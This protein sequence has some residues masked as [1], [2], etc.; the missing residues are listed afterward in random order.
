MSE[1]FDR[2]LIEHDQLEGRLNALTNFM[3]KK[4]FMKLSLVRRNLLINQHYHM[5]EYLKNLDLR[6][7]D[8]KH[9]GE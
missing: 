4:E 6:I 5:S 7:E 8:I 9:N 1:F 3:A 2:L